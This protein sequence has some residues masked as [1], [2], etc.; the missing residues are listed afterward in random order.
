MYGVIEN[1]LNRQ[2]LKSNRLKKRRHLSSLWTKKH[3]DGRQNKAS[4]A[5]LEKVLASANNASGPARNAWLA[6]LGLLAYL[7]ITLAG[8][9]DEDLLRNSLYKCCSHV[10]RS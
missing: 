5:E 10:A 2:H 7:L 1:S 9:T 6:F 3:R 8:I 4:T